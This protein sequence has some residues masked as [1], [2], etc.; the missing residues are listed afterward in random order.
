L[1]PAQDGGPKRKE[2]VSGL[3]KNTILEHTGLVI[4]AHLFRSIATKIHSMAAPGDFATI[5]HVLHNTLQTSM[6]AYA[7]FEHGASIRHYQNSVD[8]ARKRLMAR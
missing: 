6:K 4:N 5:S 8:T 1:F 7:Q 2:H 3:I